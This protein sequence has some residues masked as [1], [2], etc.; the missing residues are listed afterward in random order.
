M[1]QSF[2]SENPL[3]EVPLVPAPW[4]LTGSG[5]I[6]SFRFSDAFIE[7]ECFLPPAFQQRR[8]RNFGTL[9][10][11]DYTSSNV[12]PYRELL[13]V[14]CRFRVDGHWYWSITRIFV[15]TWDSVVNGRI[16]WGIPKDRAD[17]DVDY[18]DDGVDRVTVSKNGR[19][20]ARLAFETGGPSMPVCG[21]LAPSSLRTLVQEHEGKRYIYKPFADGQLR[22]AK[23]VE[24]EFD[25][26]V[27]PDVTKGRVVAAVKVPRFEMAFPVA[28]VRTLR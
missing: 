16:N 12:G 13:F 15:S 17:F 14:L 22:R 28:A 5:Y 10:F 27:F 1:S 20:F 26:A 21:V 24:A 3:A 7:E 9:M 11:V 6:A 8:H 2:S 23:L 4:E 25:S 19:N 18:G